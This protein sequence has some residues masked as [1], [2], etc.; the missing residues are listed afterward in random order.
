MFK[1]S[2]CLKFVTRFSL[3][4]S[5]KI[6]YKYCGI[7]VSIYHC[8]NCAEYSGVLFYM[9]FYV[10]TYIYLHLYPISFGYL[11]ILYSASYSSLFSLTLFVFVV[12]T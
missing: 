6:I 4:D 5:L 2:G 10:C 1:I 11:A 3:N 7:L 8:D 9:L 12:V